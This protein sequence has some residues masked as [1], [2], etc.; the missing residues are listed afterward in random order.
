MINLTQIFPGDVCTSCGTSENLMCL[1]I[2]SSPT[3][4]GGLHLCLCDTCRKDLRDILDAYAVFNTLTSDQFR[5]ILNDVEQIN[6][7]LYN[8]D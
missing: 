6:P 2:T 7:T 4:A 5:L 3:G 1:N 8:S